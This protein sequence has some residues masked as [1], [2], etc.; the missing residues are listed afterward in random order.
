[1]G[2]MVVLESIKEVEL[3]KECVDEHENGG[4]RRRRKSKETVEVEV[5][6]GDGG[7]YRMI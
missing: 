6:A 7:V 1:M 4:R 5:E 2:L 3:Q